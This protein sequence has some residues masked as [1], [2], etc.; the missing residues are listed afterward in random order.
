MLVN[1]LGTLVSDYLKEKMEMIKMIEL[2]YLE[3][4]VVEDEVINDGFVMLKSI[5]ID[6]N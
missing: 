6:I 4:H 2:M 1:K 3:D 5:N